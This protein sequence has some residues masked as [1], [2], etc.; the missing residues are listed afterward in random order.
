MSITFDDLEVEPSGEGGGSS[1]RRWAAGVGA[2]M[3][4][5]A[6]GGVGYGIGRSVDDSGGSLA[7]PDVTTAE[8]APSDTE[9]TVTTDAL[10]DDVPSRSAP[11]VGEISAADSGS[12]S[13]SYSSGGVGYSSFGGQPMTLLAERITDTGFVLRAHLGQTWDNGADFGDGSWQ[14]APWC[15]ESG[16]LRIALSG[17]GVIDVGG[18]PWYSEPYQGRAVSW[19][20]LGTTDGQPQWVIVAQAPPDTTNVTVTFADG[21]TDAAVPVNGIALLTAPGV[22][23]TE[24][25]EG[26][27][28]Y[29]SDTPP[30]FSVAFEGGTDPGVVTS[31]GVGTWN[32]PDFRAACEPPPPALPDPGEQPADPAAAKAE[33]VTAMTALYDS[34]ALLDGDAVYLDDSTGVSEARAQVAEG[35]YSSEASSASAV[36]EELVFTTPTEAW[37]RYRVD[38]D[39]I[40][41]SN[42]YGIAVVVDGAWKITRN[43]VCQDLSMAG[44]DCGGGWVYI[45]PPSVFEGDDSVG[46]PVPVTVPLARPGD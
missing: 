6:A 26:D 16:Q 3:L 22:A 12:S 11:L 13:T 1:R 46:I 25:V 19:L 31:D 23:P 39:G 14:P 28:S 5:A 7:S 35:G 43:T 45:Q 18:A 8:P 10:V 34:K 44:G 38:T 15:Y 17:N 40:G 41:L 24:I 21:A 42:R 30:V 32:D 29:W 4:I 2:A 20:T 37:F 27:Y 36:I 9:A 33:I